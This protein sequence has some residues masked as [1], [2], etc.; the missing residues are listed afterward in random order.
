MA[1]NRNRRAVLIVVVLVVFLSPGLLSAASGPVGWTKHAG[2]VVDVGASGAWD[3]ASVFDPAV[4]YVGATYRMWYSG[5][6]ATGPTRIGYATS[7]DGVAW[8]RQAGAP[9]LDVGAEGSWD[10]NGVRSPA[11]IYD[12]GTYKMWYTGRDAAG[13]NRIGYATSPDGITWSKH[14]GNPVL[15]L[16]G[17]G[18]WDALRVQ[19]P[20][21]VKDAGGYRM[22]YTGVDG[23][24]NYAIGYATSS[25]GVVWTKHAGNPVLPGAPAPA[26]DYSVYAPSVI[27]DGAVFRMLYSACNL[28]GTACEIGHA[29]A[30]DGS[31][32]TR[33]GRVLQ[34]GPDGAF[35]RYS[36]DYPALLRVGNE[37]KAW[38]SGYSDRYRI[39]YA[40]APWLDLQNTAYLPLTLRNAGVCPPAWSDNFA[41]YHSGWPISDDADVTYAYTGGDYQILL[42]MADAY[43][44]GSAGLRMEDGVIAV[45]MRFGAGGDAADNGGILFGQQTDEYENFYRLMVVRNGDYCIQRHDAGVG[46]EDLRCGA[47]VGYAPYPGTNT[48][49][50]VRDGAAITAYLN[51]GLLASVNDSTYSGEGQVGLVVGTSA[52]NADVRFD[53]YIVYPLACAPVV[54]P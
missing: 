22:W 9:M 26:W 49:K 45:R 28:N 51:G 7:A 21:V 43:T 36:A 39:G 52:G 30:T 34:Q 27:A 1:M 41:D 5:G 8:A 29:T 16:D 25:D 47:A 33:Q 6:Q 42:K 4:L 12:G 20:T 50:V 32:W 17:P 13:K 38:Y 3:D 18:A 40:S 14:A 37:Y 15:D 48:L 2:P 35:D 46:W 23:G 24:W 10:A 44:W 54:T 11:V 53:D 19:E 31:A